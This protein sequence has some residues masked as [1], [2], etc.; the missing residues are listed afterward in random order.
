MAPFK[1]NWSGTR[2]LDKTPLQNLHDDEHWNSLKVLPPSSRDTRG[3]LI[4]VLTF[5]ISEGYSC[6]RG[7]TGG[8]GRWLCRGC[9][10]VLEVRGMNCNRMERKSG[11]TLAPGHVICLRPWCFRI[12]NKC[13][14]LGKI[15]HLFPAYSTNDAK[16][17][18]FLEKWGIQRNV[19][20]YW[21]QL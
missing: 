9:K 18:N 21:M 7:I 12:N 1:A 10:I 13:D 19:I 17:I 15:T 8:W 2:I 6:L 3:C 20:L 16:D 11:R 4:W 14:T 5:V